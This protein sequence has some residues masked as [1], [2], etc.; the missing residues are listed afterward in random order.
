[1]ESKLAEDVLKA[2]KEVTSS[3][4]DIG[5]YME[6]LDKLLDGFK[7]TYLKNNKITTAEN[8]FNFLLRPKRYSERSHLLTNLLDAYES[9]YA[10]GA[11]CTAL[12]ALYNILAEQLELPVFTIIPSNHILS[13]IE[14]TNL[15]INIENTLQD[16]FGIRHI[17]IFENHPYIDL[18]ELPSR[19][20]RLI[21]ATTYFNSAEEAY[22]A[23]DYDYA[24]NLN[25]KAMSIEH[26]VSFSALNTAINRADP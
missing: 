9:E 21:T 18:D 7:N 24:R 16:G 15:R 5:F 2:C 6:S 14:F 13:R 12:S 19:D 22:L 8:L 11:N 26:D 17:K 3:D 10:E 23:G 4:V 20:N 25:H 1:M